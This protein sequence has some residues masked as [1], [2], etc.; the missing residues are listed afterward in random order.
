M[1]KVTLTSGGVMLQIKYFPPTV[2]SVDI[3][4]S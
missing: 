3:R 4:G 1:A 2:S